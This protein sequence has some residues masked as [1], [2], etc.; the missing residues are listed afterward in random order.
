M[1]LKAA[2]VIRQN[3]PCGWCDPSSVGFADTFSHKGRRE[4]LAATLWI[5]CHL[6]IGQ[7][8]HAR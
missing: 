5:A 3:K 2:T 6:P 8:P 1:T 7:T 4:P